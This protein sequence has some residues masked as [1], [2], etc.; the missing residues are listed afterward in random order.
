MKNFQHKIIVPR[1]NGAQRRIGI[2]GGIA[3]GKSCV[4]NF[5]KETMQ[6][7]ILD[8]DI[9]S[10]KVLAHNTLASQEI[11]KRYG[12]KVVQFNLENQKIINRQE[13]SK[14][15]FNDAQ[16]RI[17]LER[18]VHPLIKNHLLEDLELKEA[19]KTIILIIPLLFEA[20]LTDLCSEIWVVNCTFSQQRERLINRNNLS[21]Q[22]A[23]KRIKSQI[24]LKEKINLAD[25]VIDNSKEV[26]TWEKQIN[27]LLK[28]Y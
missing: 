24:P 5:I 3:S 16:E 28:N 26:K 15:I 10:R 13:L 11:I 12:T 22:E 19:Y 18:L 7:P 17:W 21:L 6:I 2:T 25:V 23:E 1:W 14:I 8:A 27:S 20:K 4:G 9:Y